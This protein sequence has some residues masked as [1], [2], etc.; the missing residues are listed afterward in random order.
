ML[1]EA[2]AKIQQLAERAVGITDQLDIE[3]VPHAVIGGRLIPLTINEPTA[4]HTRTLSS[5][6]DYIKENR[7]QLEVKDLTV[8]IVSPGRVEVI[9]R[10]RVD[11]T[12]HTYLVATEPDA[13]AKF[14]EFVNRY[15][16]IEQFIIG[17][18]RH[19]RAGFGDLANVLAVVGNITQGDVRQVEDDGITQSVTMRAGITKVGL[20]TLPSPVLL[21][22]K[23][24][25]SE[26]ELSAVPFVVRV[27]STDKLPEVALYECDGDSWKVDAAEKCAEFLQRTFDPSLR[28]IP[29][30]VIA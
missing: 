30:A 1:Q 4:L 11:R 16:N 3:E 20:A 29:F 21:V 28:S 10:L 24:S 8:H 26:V 17:M 12:R 27:R 15:M 7:D 13:S 14:G 5:V 23:R 18:Q 9:D 19:F 2:I 22:P 25:F 6:V